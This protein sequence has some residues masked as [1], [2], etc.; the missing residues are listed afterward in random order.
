MSA[1]IPLRLRL[2]LVFVVAMAT[3]LAAVGAFL[4]VRVGDS[5]LEQ[6][7]ESLSARAVEL[8]VSAR[9]GTTG[10]ALAGDDDEFA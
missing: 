2:T 3:V 4:Y 6:V 1:R 5:L 10:S 7:D 8:A 9:E